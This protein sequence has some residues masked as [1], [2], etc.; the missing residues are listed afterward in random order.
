MDYLVNL[1]QYF[2]RLKKKKTLYF[3]FS[4]KGRRNTTENYY[5]T[6]KEKYF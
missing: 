5:T 6:N 3:K 4:I 1:I 2:H